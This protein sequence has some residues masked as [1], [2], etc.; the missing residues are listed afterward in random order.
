MKNL[1][2]QL[3]KGFESVTSETCTKMISKIRK[4]EAQFWNEDLKS[5]AQ[6]KGSS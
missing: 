5:D 1:S 2:D 4:K 3:E 6:K